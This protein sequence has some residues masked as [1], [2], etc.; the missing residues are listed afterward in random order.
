MFVAIKR[1]TGLTGWRMIGGTTDEAGE[2]SSELTIA[3][4]TLILLIA[5]IWASFF[6]F[7]VRFELRSELESLL[8]LFQCSKRGFRF[9]GVIGFHLILLTTVTVI[10]SMAVERSIPPASNDATDNLA[11]STMGQMKPKKNSITDPQDRGDA[12]Q[13]PTSCKLRYSD[14]RSSRSQWK[15]ERYKTTGPSKVDRSYIMVVYKIWLTAI[16]Y[17]FLY[18]I[19]ENMIM[20]YTE[21]SL[22]EFVHHSFLLAIAR[23]T[24]IDLS[25]YPAGEMLFNP[26]VRHRI[27]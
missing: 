11:V 13:T 2:S 17:A 5:L 7:I 20:F 14:L 8:V 19:C 22:V 24:G 26:L 6:I 23:V 18:L 12:S 1:G 10:V 3:M 16:V 9:L 25:D 27:R 15:S 4:I 21:M